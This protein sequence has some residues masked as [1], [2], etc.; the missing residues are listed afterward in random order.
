V[1]FK[2]GRPSSFVVCS[3]RRATKVPLS[4]QY[5][6]KPSLRL[7]IQKISRDLI[8]RLT[9]PAPT[10]FMNPPPAVDRTRR[11]SPIAPPASTLR[12]TESPAV[13]PSSARFPHPA[14]P[15]PPARDA[16]ESPAKHLSKAAIGP[17]PASIARCSQP[18][19]R[20]AQGRH[21]ISPQ[22]RDAASGCAGRCVG[23]REAERSCPILACPRERVFELVGMLAI[24]DDDGQRTGQPLQ[25]SRS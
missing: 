14:N 20:S 11:R 9:T 24:R 1:F 13:E 2:W 7:R 16:S 21:A 19:S 5:K 8:S 15:E 22:W 6:P 10:A 18:R 23:D 17:P 12:R 25:I 3:L 4:K